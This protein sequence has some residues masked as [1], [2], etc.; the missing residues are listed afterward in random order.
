[1]RHDPTPFL[2]GAPR[3]ATALDCAR[4]M[5]EGEEVT[6][7]GFGMSEGE[8]RGFV[9]VVVRKVCQEEK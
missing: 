4:R 7:E 9:G 3:A 1:M 5:G 6:Q 8:W 2:G